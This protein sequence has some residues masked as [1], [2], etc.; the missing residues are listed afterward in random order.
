MQCVLQLGPRGD[1]KLLV[2]VRQ[3]H[4]DGPNCYEQ[5][6]RDLAVGEAFGGHA[7]NPQLARGERVDAA[8]DAA[9]GPSSGRPQLLSSALGQREGPAAFG[10]VECLAQRLARLRSAARAAQSGAQRHQC[11]RLLEARGRISQ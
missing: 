11:L 8:Q 1:F 10:E 7:G 9:A 4:L 6:L 3:V 5:F 2:S